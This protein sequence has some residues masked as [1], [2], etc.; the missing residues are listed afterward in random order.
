MV[1]ET[2]QDVWE[3][4]KVDNRRR[5]AQS[6]PLELRQGTETMMLRLMLGMCAEDASKFR[7]GG[8]QAS[9][10][11]SVTARN[12]FATRSCPRVTGSFVCASFAEEGFLALKGTT[13]ACDTRLSEEIAALAQ[14]L[15]SKHEQQHLELARID[16]RIGDEMTRLTGV[17]VGGI[18]NA[19]RSWTT[20]IVQTPGNFRTGSLQQ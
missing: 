17:L 7:I 20:R 18:V 12:K 8:S 1:S 2:E 5:G 16:C 4:A 11:C 3:I 6:L 10:I 14:D 13:T 9:V 19:A 15:G